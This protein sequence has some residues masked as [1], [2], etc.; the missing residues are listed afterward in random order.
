[1]SEKNI[2][3]WRLIVGLLIFG[4]WELFGRLVDDT[5]TSAPSEI[6]LRLFQMG[7]P[8]VLA[9]TGTTLLEMFVG[10]I[11][12]LPSGIVLGLILGRMPR[13][14]ALFQPFFIAGNS[15]PLPALAPLLI[16]WFGLGIAPKVVLVALVS[17]FLMFF[18][19]LSGARSVDGDLVDMLAVMGASSP[20]V[21]RKIVAPASVAWIFAGLKNAIPYALIAATVGEM[22]L[23]RSGLG[24]LISDAAANFDMTGLYTALLILIVLGAVLNELLALMQRR[25]LR[26]RG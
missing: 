4:S 6:A 9:N 17:F 8:A 11:I 1:M 18:T 23:A 10:L 14:A 19:T 20:E 3:L 16:L 2:G 15:I 12:G 7:L 13:T 5:W 22:L 25:F 26:W 24:F 21:F